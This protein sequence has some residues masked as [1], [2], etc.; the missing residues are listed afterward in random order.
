MPVQHCSWVQT[1]RAAAAA[2]AAALGGALQT[3]DMVEEIYGMSP[4]EVVD[5]ARACGTAGSGRERS[6]GGALPSVPLFNRVFGG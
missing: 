1:H 3:A 4:A 6:S 5:R 2:T